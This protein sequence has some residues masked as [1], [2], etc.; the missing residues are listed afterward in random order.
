MSSQAHY[1]PENLAEAARLSSRG[2]THERIAAHQG[3]ARETVSRHLA[4]HHRRALADL[5]SRRAE[6]LGQQIEQYLELIYQA[7]REWRRSR[8]DATTTTTGR[9]GTEMS[10]VARAEDG[11]VRLKE[12]IEVWEADIETASKVEGRT[13]DPRYLREIRELMADLRKLAGVDTPDRISDLRLDDAASAD[14]PE[15]LRLALERSYPETGE[16]P[17]T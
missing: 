1:S 10:Q 14:V 12:T 5:R 16:T 8:R 3:F 2:W 17:E 13:G 6:L 4:E 11:T 7:W 15:R 9:E